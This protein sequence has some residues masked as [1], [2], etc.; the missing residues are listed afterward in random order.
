MTNAVESH[1]T[2]QRLKLTGKFF[3]LIDRTDVVLTGDDER[4]RNLS[5][6]FK[7]VGLAL[8]VVW[9]VEVFFVLLEDVSLRVLHEVIEGPRGHRLNASR[10]KVCPFTDSGI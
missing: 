2:L 10:D 7:A 4:D 6:I 5:N 9:I 8:V 1:E 3:R